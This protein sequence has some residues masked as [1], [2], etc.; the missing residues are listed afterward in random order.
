M[1]GPLTFMERSLSA[2]G[3]AQGHSSALPNA[4]TLIWEMIWEMPK[5]YDR[6]G[7]VSRSRGA[8][9]GVENMHFRDFFFMVEAQGRGP[10]N[11]PF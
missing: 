1:G 5:P 11:K 10:Q 2:V 9:L 8:T 3:G 6:R 4:L 7:R